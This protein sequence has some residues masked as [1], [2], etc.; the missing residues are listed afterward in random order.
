ME[1]IAARRAK[2]D[3][4][5]A[6]RERRIR[7]T[8]DTLFTPAPRPTGRFGAIVANAGTLAAIVD[9]AILGYRLFRQVRRFIK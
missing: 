8:V 6:I 1:D 7:K 5:I 2:L 4:E 3:Q 9:G